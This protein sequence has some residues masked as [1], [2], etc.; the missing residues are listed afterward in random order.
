M[1]EE[2]VERANLQLLERTCREFA[3]EICE[4][5]TERDAGIKI[6]NDLTDA[7]NQSSDRVERERLK[8]RRKLYRLQHLNDCAIANPADARSLMQY[9]KLIDQELRA[10]LGDD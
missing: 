9:L 4:L 2:N 1:C 10:A 6:I 5:L 3:Q 7:L 8:A